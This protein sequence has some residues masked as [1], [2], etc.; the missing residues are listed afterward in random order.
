VY[1]GGLLNG[2]LGNPV[3][4]NAVLGASGAV[5]ALYGYVLAGNRLTTAIADRLGVG[6]IVEWTLALTIATILTW[7]T[8]S[9]GVA[10][11]AHFTGILLGLAAGRLDLLAPPPS[12]KADGR[13]ATYK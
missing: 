4:G 9:P 12:A 6:A 13:N 7:M 3:V 8:A 10:L 5:L 11:I 2:V 1:F